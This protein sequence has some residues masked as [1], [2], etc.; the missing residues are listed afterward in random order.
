MER[1][2]PKITADVQ[3]LIDM[4]D[5]V[6]YAKDLAP[7][8]HIK[9]DVII[10]YAKTGQWNLCRYIVSGD[11]V[12]FFRKDFLQQCGF[13]DPE[14]APEDVER[15]VYTAVID[16]LQTLLESQKETIRLLEEQNELLRR[17]M[18]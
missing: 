8:V 10:R 17:R 11:R 14:P 18:A 3:R 4:D 12:K 7:I 2:R 1:I 13:I 6:V 15:A 5:E 16:A 9:P